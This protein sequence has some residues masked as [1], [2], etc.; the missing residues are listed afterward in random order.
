VSLKI[1]I[2]RDIEDQSKQ[3]DIF[4]EPPQL[5]DVNQSLFARPQEIIDI[6]YEY[7]KL[8]LQ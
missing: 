1:L 6:G 8:L 2:N 3:C 7:T 5:V 4:I